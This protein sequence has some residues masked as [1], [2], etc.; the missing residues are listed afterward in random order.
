MTTG[1][2]ARIVLRRETGLN[3]Y[4]SAPRPS[5]VLAYASSTANDI[6]VRAFAHV[7]ALALAS[8]IGPELSGQAY[9]GRRRRG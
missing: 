1:G 4:H 6:S 3:N 7:Q 5:G 2:D 8:E 9:A